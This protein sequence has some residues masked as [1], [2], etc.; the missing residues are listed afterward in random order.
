MHAVIVAR[1]PTHSECTRFSTVLGR[2]VSGRDW[3]F[4]LF[5]RF[6]LAISVVQQLNR[7]SDIRYPVFIE[8]LK[9]QLLAGVLVDCSLFARAHAKI[10]TSKTYNVNRP[11]FGAPFNFLPPF[12]HQP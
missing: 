5:F 2:A 4:L 11:R 1:P 3:I 8:R 6:L 10:M 7:M 12:Q 9:Q